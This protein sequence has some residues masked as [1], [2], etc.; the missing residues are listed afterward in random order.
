FKEEEAEQ[1]R[2]ISQAQRGELGQAEAIA[3]SPVAAAAAAAVESNYAVDNER[4]SIDIMPPLADESG[5]NW[6]ADA[7]FVK[8]P[9]DSGVRTTSVTAE[10]EYD[11]QEDIKTRT[12]PPPPAPAEPATSTASTAPTGVP[13]LRGSQIP[14]LY[15]VLAGLAVLLM[16]AIAWLIAR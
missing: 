2:L 5:R 4:T 13:S 12:I 8:H 6:K 1:R 11:S 3:V 14:P 9:A 7:D 10:P 15:Y 16:V